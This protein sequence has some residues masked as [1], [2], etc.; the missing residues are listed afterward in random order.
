MSEIVNSEVV[1][2]QYFKGDIIT[3]PC[4]L[5]KK[6]NENTRPK[7]E[8]YITHNSLEKYPDYKPFQSDIHE[9]ELR[10][11]NK[12]ICEWERD[13][14]DWDKSNYGYYTKLLILNK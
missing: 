4:Y 10:D 11:Y 8:D 9:K 1:R 5:C 6:P 14:D 3:D 13:Y 7:R 2:E 12:A